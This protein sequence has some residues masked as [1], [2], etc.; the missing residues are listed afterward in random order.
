MKRQL[1]AVPL[2][3]SLGLCAPVHAGG[4]D[5]YLDLSFDDLLKIKFQLPAALTRLT[6]LEAPASTTVISAADIRLTPAR[7]LYDL[8]E[9][10]VP[11]A[12]WTNSEQGPHLNVR[13]STANRNYQYLLLV[14]GQV[15]N[16][17]AHAG[18][19]A[20]LEQW[21]MSDIERVE[22]VRGPGSVTY[23]PGA[24]AGVISIT[25]LRGKGAPGS[26]ASA[27]Y[28]SPYQSRALTLSH[29][30]ESADYSLFA[31]ASVVR[32]PGVQQPL[33][34]VRSNGQ[35]GFVGHDVF[36]SNAPM[37]YFAD[38]KDQ[39]Q[40]KLHLRLDFTN[41]W[42][43]WSRF[44]QQG[45]TWA[46][47][48]FKTVFAGVPT[49]EQGLRS[50]ELS[51]NVQ[52]EVALAPGLTLSAR[53]SAESNDFERRASAARVPDP[54]HTLNYNVNFA[55]SDL[56]ARAVLN[57]QATPWAQLALGAE[58]SRDHFGAGWGD[59]VHDMR[60]GESGDIVNSPDSKAIQKGNGN[61]ADRLLPPIFVGDGWSASTRSLFAE[62]NL[63]VGEHH[64]LLLSSR[65]DKNTYSNSLFSPRVVWI[66][67]V[68]DGHVLRLSAQRSSRMNTAAQMFADSV[69]GRASDAERASSL[70]AAYTA[71]LTQGLGFN[72]ALFRSSDAIIS[73]QGFDNTDRLTGQLRTLG[74][75][76][77][78]HY[79]WE[80]GR[81]GMN[82]SHVRLQDWTLAPGITRSGISYADYHT[83]LPGAG[84]QTGFGDDLNN[85]PNNAVKVFGNWKFAEGWTMHAD[86]RWTSTMQ[87]ALDGLEALKR[88]VAGTP[89]ATPAFYAALERIAIEHTYA[90]DLRVNALLEYAITR[91]AALQLFGQNLIGR[92][93]NKRY[94]QDDGN[95]A[96]APVRVRF[97]DEPAT[98]GVRFTY[99]F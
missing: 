23:G 1:V 75:E 36:P 9:V 92:Y 52:K 91:T 90:S 67:S 12:L 29:R 14:D 7:N 47:N 3:V 20:E 94:A 19:S 38:F 24:V 89:A 50:R 11:G 74:A 98:L 34:Q 73:F 45:S 16:N 5:D 99:H 57:W 28:V 4:D 15:M 93:G 61:S 78:L 65:L 77:E 76:G 17:R 18:A 85:W 71:Q 48:E 31:H 46:S 27:T 64:K 25:T 96:A 63:N 62:A 58:L 54:N 56:T 88:A 22:I 72:L 55:E 97:V 68:A 95:I 2:L 60:L 66:S 82:V 86:A 6:L 70:E 59:D 10:Y 43:W 33:F 42:Q 41:G 13:G 87:G 8:I 84:I 44:T 69:R 39:P 35:A 40:L 51:S 80:R 53:L 83:Q 21:D 26:V 30:D 49:N 32:T 37:E 79:N 81:I